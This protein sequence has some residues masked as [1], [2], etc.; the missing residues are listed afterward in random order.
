MVSGIKQQQKQQHQ[1]QQNKSNNNNNNK[2]ISAITDQILDEL[3]IISSTETTKTTIQQRQ[4][5]TT[6]HTTTIYHLLLT[7]FW[8]NFEV[9]FLG[10]AIIT[11][12]TKT[13]TTTTK[14]TATTTFLG[15]D[16]IELNLVINRNSKEYKR[17]NKSMDFPTILDKKNPTKVILTDLVHGFLHHQNVI[18]MAEIWLQ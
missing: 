2:Y 6:T 3:Q 10:P 9:G 11:T 12:T 18:Q 17:L 1:Q 13:T 4:Q 16:S 14:T 5:E 8:P 7:E 15:C